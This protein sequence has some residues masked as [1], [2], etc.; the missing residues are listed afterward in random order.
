MT[1]KDGII[2]SA[3]KDELMQLYFRYDY[4]LS[5]SFEEYMNRVKIAGVRLEAEHDN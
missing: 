4:C 3:T 2:T 5:M 1:T